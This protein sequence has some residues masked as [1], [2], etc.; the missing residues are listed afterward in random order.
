MI[1]NLAYAKILTGY[2]FFWQIGFA[3]MGL[4]LS[5]L[6]VIAE[7]RWLRGKE[8]VWLSLTQRWA[9]ACALLFSLAAVSGMVLVFIIG[10]LW[11]GLIKF[12]GSVLGLPLGVGGFFFFLQSIF[13]GITLYGWNKVG[14]RTHLFIGLA[15][16]VSGALSSLFLV[17]ANGYLHH[18]VGMVII[19]GVPTPLLPLAVFSSPFAWIKSSHALFAAYAVSGFSVASLHAFMLLKNPQNL[20][21]RK[22]LKAS[23]AMSVIAIFFV[24]LSGIASLRQVNQ[25]QPIKLAAFAGQFQSGQGLPLRLG[26]WADDKTKL[27][28]SWISLPGALSFL[29][30]G[31]RDASF[32]GIESVP[33]DSWPP[34]RTVSIL[35]QAMWLGGLYLILLTVWVLVRWSFKKTSHD[36]KLLLRA[37]VPALPCAFL[38]AQ[39]GWISSEMGRQPWVLYNLIKSSEILTPSRPLSWLVLLIT[40]LLLMLTGVILWLLTHL[41]TESPHWPI[42]ESR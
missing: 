31:N 38:S 2:L 3:M 23:L 34:I 40:T 14:R 28:S 29:I 18:P 26:A 9:K 12:A 20:F 16:S 21:H 10:L 4:G 37:L 25:H 17:L 13:L 6:M 42:K 7:W 41:T 27:T 5:L 19:G 39:A 36:S 33:E 11:P 35:F 24:M 15:A 22:G 8:D 1:T 30:H 32:V